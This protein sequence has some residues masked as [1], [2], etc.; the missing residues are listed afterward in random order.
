MFDAHNLN[1]YKYTPVGDITVMALCVIM[2][3]L[4]WQ[5]YIYKNRN[6]RMI[7]TILCSIFVASATDIMYEVFLSSD[8]IKP[9]PTY[10]FRAVHHIILTI[11]LVLYINYL[12]E[13]LW[14]P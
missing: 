5:T 4:V 11:V 12:H 7:I 2:T 8:H 14:V 6:F 13:P 3:L 10:I 9:M 1:L